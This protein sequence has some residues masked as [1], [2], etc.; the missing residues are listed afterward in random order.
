MSDELN[1]V[2]IEDWSVVV[3]GSPYTA[4]ELMSQC[5]YGIVSRHRNEYLN[6]KEVR[7]S[8][9]VGADGDYIVTSSGS[10]YE[11][12]TPS[13]EY[14]RL[15]PGARERLFNTIRERAPHEQTN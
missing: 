9:I 3:S 13:E 7:T 15:Y 2:K 11:L 12:G 1:I 5:L 10:R 6:G 4:P 8:R 14:E